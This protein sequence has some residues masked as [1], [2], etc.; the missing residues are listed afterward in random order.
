M[1]YAVA[2]AGA[3][4]LDVGPQALRKRLR[5]RGLLAS[6]DAGRHMLQVRRTLAGQPRLVL[7][8]RVGDFLGSC[9]TEP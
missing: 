3:A 2:Q 4:A 8:L 1:S 5:Q 7:H 6:V 9:G